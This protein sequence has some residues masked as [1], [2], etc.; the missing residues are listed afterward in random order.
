MRL[1]RGKTGFTL[2]ELLV[3]IAIIG[4]LIALLLPAVQA[5]RE[6]ARRSQCTNNMKQLALAFHNYEGTAKT[7]PSWFYGV[8]GSTAACP[9]GD[10]CGCLQ[11]DCPRFGTS[12]YVLILPFIEQA[13]LY[14]QWQ[15]PCI[16]RNGVNFSLCMPGIHNPVT[17]VVSSSNGIASFRCPSDM[18]QPNWAQCNYAMSIG[19]NV[20]W[21]NNGA[22]DN[23]MFQWANETPFASVT[24]GLSNTVMLGEQVVGNNNSGAQTF[25][26]NSWGNT[27][28]QCS[29]GSGGFTNT[30]S[31]PNNLPNGTMAGLQA[32]ITACGQAALQ[33]FA[34]GTQINNGCCASAT[35]AAANGSAVNELAPPNWQYPNW[36]STGGCSNGSSIIPILA[37]NIMPPRSHHPGGVNVAMGDASVHFVTQTVDPTTWANLG[38]RNDGLPVTLP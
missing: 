23:G 13:P 3:V 5:A 37:P 12:A 10:G 21:N 17:G 1:F 36:T 14:S 35:W 24:D 2:V 27:A 6:A 31:Y 28:T 33:A 25:S 15:M 9:A 8:N 18:Y 29:T 4:I 11:K 34:S 32:A 26:A 30:T 7:L 19:P 38:C 22:S 20:A 16:W